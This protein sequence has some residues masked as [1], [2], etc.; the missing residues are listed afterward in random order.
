MRT[1]RPVWLVFRNEQLN[2]TQNKNII[3]KAIGN[4][5]SESVVDFSGRIDRSSSEPTKKSHL[6]R[7]ERPWQNLKDLQQ[8]ENAVMSSNFQ[9]LA[10][11]IR[12]NRS[13]VQMRYGF[14]TE[15]ATYEREREF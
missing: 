14:L 9:G 3:K 12:R 7:R 11:K 13:P 6:G 8:H 4:S 1:S 10:E 15:C 5:G 2:P